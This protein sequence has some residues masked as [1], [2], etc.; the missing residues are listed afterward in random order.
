MTSR[1]VTVI[2]SMD[3][4]PSAHGYIDD[5]GDLLIDTSPDR[6]KIYLK[7]INCTPTEFKNWLLIVEESLDRW[8]LISCGENSIIN[9][10]ASRIDFSIGSELEISF[11][12]YIDALIEVRIKNAK[13]QLDKLIGIK[14]RQLEITAVIVSSDIDNQHRGLS[15][16]S[17]SSQI[18]SP[19][20][21]VLKK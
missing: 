20:K 21:V 16:K 7:G 2:G 10:G 17:A 1:K 19:V 13:I 12:D 4:G 18:P 6:T 3:K 11:D 5:E 15:N 14:K 9:I 8:D